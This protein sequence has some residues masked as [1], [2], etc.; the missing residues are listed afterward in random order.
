VQNTW[1]A[2]NVEQI[3]QGWCAAVVRC[4]ACTLRLSRLCVFNPNSRWT[5]VPVYER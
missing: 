4:I 5:G 1:I 3:V 2:V